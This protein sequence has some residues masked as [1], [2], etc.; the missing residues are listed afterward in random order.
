[1]KALKGDFPNQALAKKMQA[2]GFKLGRFE[3]AERPGVVVKVEGNS[4]NMVEFMQFVRGDEFT[5][6]FFDKTEDGTFAHKHTRHELLGDEKDPWKGGTY[7]ELL[8]WL[9]GDIDMAKYNA[10]KDRLRK[11]GFDR[12]LREKI[13][14]VSPKRKRC[15]SEHDGEWDMSRR[16]EIMPF[17]NTRKAIGAGRSIKIVINLAASSGVSAEKIDKFGV[18]VWAIS[19]LIESSG[20]QTEIIARYAGRNIGTGKKSVHNEFL[21]NLKEATQFVT[22]MRLAACFKTAFFRRAIFAKLCIATQLENSKLRTSLGS[23]LHGAYPIKFLPGEGILTMSVG[24]V[25]LDAN[26]MENEILEAVR[27]TVAA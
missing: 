18:T 7:S 9:S 19:D 12:K 17:Q 13:A 20:I 1:M 26:A 15:M 16:W 8:N 6:E 23:P 21:I 11:S 2:M 14:M 22:P 10:E 25:D 27:A 5:G 24:T 3:D 4:A